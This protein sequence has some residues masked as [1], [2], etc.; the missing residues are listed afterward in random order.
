MNRWSIGRPILTNAIVIVALV[1]V[2]GA[3]TAAAALVVRSTNI[4]DGE[5]KTVDLANSAVTNPKIAANA[6]TGAKVDES[7]LGIVPNANM[8]DGKDSTAFVSGPGRVLFDDS[9]FSWGDGVYIFLYGTAL[10]IGFNVLAHCYDNKFF[11]TNMGT[12]PWDVW[13]RADGG[14]PVYGQTGPAGTWPN[15][16]VTATGTAAPPHL[17]TMHAVQPSTGRQAFIEMSV[18]GIPPPGSDGYGNC[19]TYATA[20]LNY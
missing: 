12:A 7:T 11:F 14:D 20:T 1:T 10:D 5:V 18:R 16:T 17:A 3:G 9:S 15:D 8:L 13:I 19:Y 2:F 6:V 4:V